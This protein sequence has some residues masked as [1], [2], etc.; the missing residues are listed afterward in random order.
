MDEREELRG[1]F[2][3]QD[4]RFIFAVKLDSLTWRSMGT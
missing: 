1:C 4:V 3:Y 2:L